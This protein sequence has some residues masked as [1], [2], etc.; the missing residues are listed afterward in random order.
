MTDKL[1]IEFPCDFPIKIIGI[2]SNNFNSDI[3]EIIL[4]HFPNTESNRITYKTSEKGNYA[5][6]TATVYPTCQQEL[7][8]LYRELTQYPG[9]K[10][11]L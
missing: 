6:I 7:D 11:V 3:T 1:I 10:M 8:A 9:I 4:K 2:H 5:A